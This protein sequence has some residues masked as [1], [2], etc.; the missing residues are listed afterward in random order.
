VRVNVG[1]LLADRHAVRVL[2]FREWLQPLGEEVTSP[3]PVEGELM[4]SGTGRSVCLSGRV[5][6]VVELVC[7]ACLGAYRQPLEVQIAEEFGRDVAPAGDASGGEQA[8]S[9]DDFMAPLEAG[10]ILDVTEVVRQHLVMA[11]PL[12]PRCRETCRGLCPRCGT[13]LNTG[14]CSCDRQETDPRLE[15]LRGWSPEKGRRGV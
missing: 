12:A 1:D 6:T 10:D 14:A 7:G 9:P 8:L 11:L 2:P 15:P 5:R 3:E 13:N 4:L